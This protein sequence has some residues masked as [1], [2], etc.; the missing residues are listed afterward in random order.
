MGLSGA[1]DEGTNNR[2]LRYLKEHHGDLTDVFFL[3]TDSI[4]AVATSFQNGTYIILKSK[5]YKIQ[6]IHF[7]QIILY[8]IICPS[9][10]IV[11]IA[12][13]GSTCRLLKADGKVYGGINYYE[14]YNII[15]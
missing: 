5:F 7:P 4:A 8:N 6:Y 11:L 9:G 10:G 2:M 15:Q 12:G 3:T 14:Y 1:E 13:T